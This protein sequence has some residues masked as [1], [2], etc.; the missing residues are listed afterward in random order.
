MNMDNLR[1]Y[2]REQEIKTMYILGELINKYKYGEVS[3]YYGY[4]LGLREVR[5]YIDKLKE[6]TNDNTEE[7]KL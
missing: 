7:E 2:I 3:M 5:E 4:Q 1:E 6:N